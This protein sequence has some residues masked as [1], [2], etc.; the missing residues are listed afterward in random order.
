MDDLALDNINHWQSIV[1]DAKAGISQAKEIAADQIRAFSAHWPS[2]NLPAIAK[3]AGGWVGRFP[4]PSVVRR[5]A[6]FFKFRTPRFDASP[7]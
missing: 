7:G 2:S 6:V 1:C 5:R 4:H 3:P